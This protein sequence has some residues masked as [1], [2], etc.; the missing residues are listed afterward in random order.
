MQCSPH[1]SIDH[2]MKPPMRYA[3]LFVASLFSIIQ[4]ALADLACNYGNSIDS[5]FHGVVESDNVVYAIEGACA[6]NATTGSPATGSVFIKASNGYTL[7]TTCTSF[8]MFHIGFKL[9]PRN[10]ITQCKAGGCI[11]CVREG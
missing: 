3:Q 4:L 5:R 10:W 2:K 6:S 11:A 9:K 1:R 7:E 8:Q